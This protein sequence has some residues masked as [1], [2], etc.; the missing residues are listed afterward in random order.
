MTAVTAKQ[1]LRHLS[2]ARAGFLAAL[3]M[4]GS[5]WAAAPPSSAVGNHEVGHLQHLV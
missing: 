5:P 4:G 3:A 2:S 1:T